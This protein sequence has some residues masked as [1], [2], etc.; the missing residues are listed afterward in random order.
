MPL[1]SGD[2]DDLACWLRLAL[3]PGAG[4]VV[5]RTLL[6]ACGLP[7]AIFESAGGLL[8]GVAGPRLAAAL[9]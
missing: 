6:E 3:T 8:D 5:V 9:R 1:A 2:A 7:N 4:P